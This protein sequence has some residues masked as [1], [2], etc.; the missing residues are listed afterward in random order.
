MNTTDERNLEACVLA[1]SQWR[2]QLPAD[3]RSKIQS[4]GRQISQNDSA[5]NDL[6]NLLKQHTALSSAYEDSRRELYQRY[7]TRPR[8]KSGAAAIQNG[9]V[10]SGNLIVDFASAILTAD[11][12]PSTAQKLVSQPSWQSQVNNAS[13]DV[14]TFFKA[15]KDSVTK[16]DAVSVQLM[17]FLDKDVYTLKELA[18]RM[19][20]PEEQIKPSLESLWQDNYIYP[21][22]K[23]ILGNLLGPL[24]V[25]TKRKSSLD[26]SSYLALT[27]KGYFHLHP[28]F[29]ATATQAQ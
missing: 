13:D 28:Y 17:K 24:N 9:A 8:S 29:K 15:L 21:V 10:N 16:P 26:T 6:R 12:F 22:S 27:A 14:K 11:H 25:F 1:L 5:V 2:G 23:S 4:A 20:L 19:E 18:Y 7:N 3:L